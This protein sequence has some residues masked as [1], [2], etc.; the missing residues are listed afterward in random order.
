MGIT[1]LFHL[2]GKVAIVTG[3]GTSVPATRETPGQFQAVLDVN[4]SGSYWMTRR[5]GES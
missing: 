5:A 1:D 4:L 3:I 2:R